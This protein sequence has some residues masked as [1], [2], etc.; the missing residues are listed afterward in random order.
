MSRETWGLKREPS[1]GSLEREQGV[2][3]GFV[4]F[5]GGILDRDGILKGRCGVPDVA[6]G[7]LLSDPAIGHRD[8]G[9]ATGL[10]IS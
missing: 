3:G 9:V 7:I 5:F 6:E 2:V 10:G 1:P 8:T 4:R